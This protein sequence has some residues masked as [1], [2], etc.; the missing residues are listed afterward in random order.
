[1]AYRERPTVYSWSRPVRLTASHNRT[2]PVPQR[3]RI[4]GRGQSMVEF[5]LVIPVFLLLL[6]GTLEVGMAYKT[7]S[8]FQEAALE[9]VRVAATSGTSGA[10]SQ[11]DKDA[12]DEL[13]TMLAAE[14]LKS[15]RS[16]TIYRANDGYV[17]LLS[18]LSGLPACSLAGP[19]PCYDNI[20]TNYVYMNGKFVCAANNAQIPPTPC[21]N[22]S[23]WDPT[24]RNATVPTSSSQ[25][26]LDIIGIRIVYNY[27]SIT[28]FLPPTTITQVATAQIEPSVYGS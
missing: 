17:P 4:D 25:A 22:E 5:A 21:T 3:G 24:Q 20:H 6:F 14:N 28:G 16:V 9:A 10:A 13:A 26:A 19:T 11:A 27:R 23:Y 7:H 1:M 18:D 12:F 8:A 15:I 2:R